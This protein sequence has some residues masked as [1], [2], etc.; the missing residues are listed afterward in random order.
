[1]ALSSIEMLGRLKEERRGIRTSVFLAPHANG[2]SVMKG[3]MSL[4]KAKFLLGS[5]FGTAWFLETSFSSYA[6]TLR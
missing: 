6:F 1:M 5:L 2:Q 3:H 4:P